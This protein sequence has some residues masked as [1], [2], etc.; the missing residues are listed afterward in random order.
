[1]RLKRGSHSSFSRSSLSTVSSVSLKRKKNVPRV[2]IAMAMMIPDAKR[3][4]R[5]PALSTRRIETEKYIL[6]FCIFLFNMRLYWLTKCCNQLN[7]PDNVG[8]QIL[9]DSHFSSIEDCDGIED[10]SVDTLKVRKIVSLAL[11]I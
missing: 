11:K 3:R 5:R 10:D 4:I 8:S 1:M 9:I 7:C 2:P 6:N